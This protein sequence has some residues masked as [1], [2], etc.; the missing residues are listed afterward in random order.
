MAPDGDPGKKSSRAG[1]L[2]SLPERTVRSLTAL[3]AGFLRET[4]DAA[5]PGRFRR[6][7]VYRAIVE[8][9]LRFLIEN[10]GKVEGA[11]AEAGSLP[12]DFLVRRTAGNGIDWLSL[13]IFHVSPVWVL[14]GLADLSGAGGSLLKEMARALEREGLLTG[15]G[16]VR[17]MA[18]FLDALERGSGELAET[19]NS[20][21]LNVQQLR[22][23]W[24]R[25]RASVAEKPEIADL[26]RQW[27]Q[28]NDTAAHEHRNVLEISTAVALHSLRAAQRMVAE[29][30]WTHYEEVLGEIGR[31]GFAGFVEREMRP[32]WRAALE[33]FSPGKS[34]ITGKWLG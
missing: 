5:I 30:V 19:V 3:A 13:A 21:P 17:S 6:T 20:P 34:T 26:E 8:T 25:L 4:G 24:D 32:Y 2:V 14:A 29:P 28:L 1:Y 10:V 22:E 11:Y 33:N 18:D 7:R 31:V 16:N 9:T 23:E 12:G 15:A 27:E